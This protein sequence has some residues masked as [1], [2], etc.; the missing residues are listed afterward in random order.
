DVVADMIRF[1]EDKSR[2]EIRMAA[3]LR[4]LQLLLPSP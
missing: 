1:G 3:T 2:A 4:A